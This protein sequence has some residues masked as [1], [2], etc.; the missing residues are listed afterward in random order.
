MGLLPRPGASWN[1]QS[2]D[3]DL[4]KVLDP[5]IDSPFASTAGMPYPSSSRGSF[6][7]KAP[8]GK[9]PFR[10]PKNGAVFHIL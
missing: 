1:P 4:S 6:T 5:I 9:T 7:G 2:E 3:F 10:A 8:Y